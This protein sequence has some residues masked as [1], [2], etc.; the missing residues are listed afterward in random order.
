MEWTKIFD[1]VLAGM[2]AAADAEAMVDVSREAFRLGYVTAVNAV[3]ATLSRAQQ[4]EG[5]R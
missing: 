5:I 3:I 4:R 1:E 2:D